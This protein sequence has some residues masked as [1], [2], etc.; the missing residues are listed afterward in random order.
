LFTTSDGGNS[1]KRFVLP[2]ADNIYFSDPQMGW[3]VGGAAGDE[4]FQT[5]DGGATW[6]DVR[7]SDIHGSTQTAVYPPLAAH[8]RGLLAVTTAGAEN[9]LKIYSLENYDQWLPLDQVLL[10]A[11]RVR[12]DFRSSM[13]KV[14]WG[15]SRE[16]N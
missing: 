12:L 2:L 16:Q 4:I 11:P 10:D 6:K 14:L 8:G 5:Q 13:R 9:K 1:W 3:A 15:R 7:P